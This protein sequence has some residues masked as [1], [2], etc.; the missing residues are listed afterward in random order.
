MKKFLLLVKDVNVRS[1][2]TGDKQARITLESLNPTD[3]EELAKLA[4]LMEVTVT[5][6]PNDS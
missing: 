2:V 3:I 6:E 1:L 4:N 5:F